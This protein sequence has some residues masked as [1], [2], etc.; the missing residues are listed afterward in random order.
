MTKR[1]GKGQYSDAKRTGGQKDRIKKRTSEPKDTSKG[2]YDKHPKWAFQRCDFDHS[3]WGMACNTH[4]LTDFFKYLSALECQTWSEI[5][6]ATSGRKGSTRNHYIE[7]PKLVK[8]A[9][10]RAIELNLDEFD[11][12]CSIAT[13]GRSRIWGYIKEGIF[14]IVW[15][16][17][18]HEICPSMKRHT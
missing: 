2:Y 14:Y 9:Q 11:E 17:P 10:A 8:K 13:A 7:L 6:T 12:L 4:S 18:E 15:F 5:L 16:D 1:T 3:K